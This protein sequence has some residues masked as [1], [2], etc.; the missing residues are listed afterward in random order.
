MREKAGLRAASPVVQMALDVEQDRV[1]FILLIQFQATFADALLEL[2]T[3]DLTRPEALAFLR[4]Q[5]STEGEFWKAWASWQ[6]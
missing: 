5:G 3:A 6:A 4:L 1:L 2:H